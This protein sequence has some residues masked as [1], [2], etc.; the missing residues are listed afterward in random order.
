MPDTYDFKYLKNLVR[1]RVDHE[2]IDHVIEDAINVAIQDIVSRSSFRFMSSI[3]TLATVAS[4]ETYTPPTDTDIILQIWDTTN[5]DFIEMMSAFDFMETYGPDSSPQEGQP[6]RA[7]F[8]ESDNVIYFNPVPSGIFNLE[9]H[10]TESHPLL[11]GES[12]T[13]KIPQKYMKVI[14]DGAVA[15]VKSYQD[16]GNA[17]ELVSYEAGINRMIAKDGRFKGIQKE[18][19]DQF[20]RRSRRGPRWESGGN[21]Y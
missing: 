9:L 7:A 15:D 12:E 5:Q 14:V 2:D 8:V 20:R 19:F 10:V 6:K 17:K 1:R 21:I 18:M 16:R 11:L 4:Q 3:K 13:T